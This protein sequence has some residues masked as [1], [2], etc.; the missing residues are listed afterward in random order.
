[1]PVVHKNSIFDR[2]IIE[3]N[4]S[5]FDFY[6]DIIDDFIKNKL[7][8]NLPK[9]SSG[10]QN[11]KKSFWNA[12][13]DISKFSFLKKLSNIKS[14]IIKKPHDWNKFFPSRDFKDSL[15]ILNIQRTEIQ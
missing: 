9:T 5:K 15:E 13:L 7:K 8:G 11:Y 6:N 1:M 3:F 10:V 2:K 12:V 14:L 4:V